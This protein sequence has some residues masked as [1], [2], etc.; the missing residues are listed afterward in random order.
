MKPGDRIDFCFGQP[1]LTT[2]PFY[3]VL[4]DTYIDSEGRECPPSDHYGIYLEILLQSGSGGITGSNQGTVQGCYA[5]NSGSAAVFGGALA[6]KNLGMLAG[7][8]EKGA[9]ACGVNYALAEAEPVS[10]LYE[11]AFALNEQSGR[12]LWGAEDVYKRQFLRDHP[13]PARGSGQCNR[14]R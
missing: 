14:L 8:F 7:C 1:Q 5:Q 13:Q 11:A 10:G 9:E 6:G 2:T 4:L 3:K 12:T